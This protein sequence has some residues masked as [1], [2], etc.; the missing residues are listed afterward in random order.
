MKK[1]T[2][3]RSVASEQ[4]AKAAGEAASRTGEPWTP[5]IVERIPIGEVTKVTVS[6]N[7]GDLMVAGS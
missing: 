7:S 2:F 5:P 3:D 4:D 6:L 1:D